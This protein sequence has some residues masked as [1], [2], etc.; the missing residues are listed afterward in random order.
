MNKLYENPFDEGLP[1]KRI[2]VD[3]DNKYFIENNGA[4]YSSDMKT[5]YCIFGGNGMQ[6][7]VV[8]NSVE[9]IEIGGISKSNTLKYII[10][11]SSVKI[12]N[13][14]NFI[15]IPSVEFIEIQNYNHSIYINPL[16]LLRDSPKNNTI[17]HYI[18]IHIPSCDTYCYATLWWVTLYFL[19]F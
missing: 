2:S 7:F 12:I 11:P 19:I 6:F 17:I 9:K 13:S 1:I 10:I 14:F 3:P 16:G 4:L 15:Q 5:L 18:P 8:P